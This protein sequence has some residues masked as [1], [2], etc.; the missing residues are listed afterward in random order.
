MSSRVLEPVF[1]AREVAVALLLAF[2]VEAGILLIWIY[3]GA[4]SVNVRAEALEAP[5]EIPIK[6][7]P[8]MD[9][10]PLLKLGG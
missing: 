10:L 7:K 2:L 1:Q 8:I 5:K 9:E 4:G 3:A 6:V